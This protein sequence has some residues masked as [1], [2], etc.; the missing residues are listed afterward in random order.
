MLL[1]RSANTRKGGRGGGAL[2]GRYCHTGTALSSSRVRVASVTKIT[3]GCS[4]HRHHH[5]R[6][7]HQHP[8]GIRLRSAANPDTEAFKKESRATLQIR[9]ILLPRSKGWYDTASLYSHSLPRANKLSRTLA[10]SQCR[11]R[12]APSESDPVV[13]RRIDDGGGREGGRERAQREENDIT[14]I[15][16]YLMCP[17]V[18]GS[19]ELCMCAC[20]NRVLVFERFKDYFS[21]NLCWTQ[22]K[23]CIIYMW[24][25][26]DFINDDYQ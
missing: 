13:E 4:H 22:W 15:F 25:Y 26:Q 17:K 20:W 16:Y 9:F 6:H 24:Q 21:A 11:L 10:P 7:S 19:C 5:R 1:S 18:H 2:K 3:T 14:V 8:R 23:I 12:N